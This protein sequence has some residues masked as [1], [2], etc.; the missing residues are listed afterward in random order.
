MV[1][2]LSQRD[3]MRQLVASLGYDREAV[4]AAY[5]DAEADGIVP[6]LSNTLNKS[7]DDYA[8]ALWRDGEKKGWLRSATGAVKR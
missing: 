6:R 8:L 2:R 5:A 4:T 1:Q 3:Y 7:A